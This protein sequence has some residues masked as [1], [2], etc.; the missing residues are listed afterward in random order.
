MA[1]ALDQMLEADERVAFRTSARPSLLNAL[2]FGVL[3]TIVML[4]VA[5]L[6]FALTGSADFWVPITG[7]LG[8]PL[9]LVFCL[10][11]QA[12]IIVTDR[13]LLMGRGFLAWL[14]GIGPQGQSIAASEIDRIA[15]YESDKYAPIT[16]VLLDG[17]QFSLWKFK[18]H[19]Q[20]RQSLADMSGKPLHRMI[21]A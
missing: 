19:H 14:F 18:D 4:A 11:L 5:A 3:L 2:A 13:R 12:E 1:G 17:R 10:R 7:M 6:V 15:A 16:I 21:A 9:A 8:G 20:F